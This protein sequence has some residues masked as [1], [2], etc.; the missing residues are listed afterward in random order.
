MTMTRPFLAVLALAA[1]CACAP[2]PELIAADKDSAPP[3]A[4][5]PLDEILARA[6]PDTP[7][8]APAIRARAQSLQARAAAIAASPT[9]P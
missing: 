8:P 7:D 5:L 6:G 4:L 1:L 9:S 3:P 2:F